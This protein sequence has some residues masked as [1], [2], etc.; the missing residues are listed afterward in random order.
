MPR[1]AARHWA[2]RTAEGALLYLAETGIEPIWTS[3]GLTFSKHLNPSAF[4]EIKTS[5]RLDSKERAEQVREE[6]RK[7]DDWDLY[8]S[9]AA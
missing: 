4:R 2:L 6:L 3:G 9:G 7:R 1:S 8:R 5:L